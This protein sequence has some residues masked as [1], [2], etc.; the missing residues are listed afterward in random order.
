M[1]EAKCCPFCGEKPTVKDKVQNVEGFDRK[2]RFF[3][4]T[5]LEC[6]NCTWLRNTH[7]VNGISEHESSAAEALELCHDRVVG[8]WNR[9][10]NASKQ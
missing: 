9:R 8:E 5:R 1:L 10:A 4:E 6:P 7:W 2:F 3:A